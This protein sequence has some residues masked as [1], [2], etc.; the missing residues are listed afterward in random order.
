MVVPSRKLS[1]T[2]QPGGRIEVVMPDLQPGQLVDVVVYVSQTQERKESAVDILA[3]CPGHLVFKTAVEVDA[4]VE[5]E[6]NSW[7]R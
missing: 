6:R 1:T 7:D 4:Y 3:R 2:V 5:N